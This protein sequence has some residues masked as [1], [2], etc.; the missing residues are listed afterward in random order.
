MY[1]IHLSLARPFCALLHST[2]SIV[3]WNKHCSYPLCV[4]PWL[5]TRDGFVPWGNLAISGYN[6][7]CHHW[8]S[9]RMWKKQPPVHTK[10]SCSEELPGNSATVEK[11]GCSLKSWGL[12]ALG[13]FF[14]AT[15]W[16]YLRRLEYKRSLCFSTMLPMCSCGFSSWFIIP[17]T[18][19]PKFPTGIFSYERISI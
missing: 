2:L 3:L 18:Q 15:Q 12:K 14:K 5:S 17:W 1:I 11:P 6:F 7:A 10:T 4:H 8:G 19:G 13:N 16:Y 9:Q